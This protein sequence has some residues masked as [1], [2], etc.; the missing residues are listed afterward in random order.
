MRSIHRAAF[1]AVAWLS[2][3]A[4]YA[5]SGISLSLT[6]DG[7][8]PSVPNTVALTLSNGTG[9]DIFIYSYNSAFAQPEG[10]TT[11]NCFNITDAFGHEVDYKGRYVVMGAPPPSLF[12]RIRPGEHLD[13]RV[14][15]SL[16]YEL[17]PA[18]SITVKTRV[19]IYDRV[20]TILPSGESESIPHESIESNAASFVAVRNA[21]H[22]SAAS[23]TIQCTPDQKDTT[24]RAIVGAK[25]IS[26]EAANFLGTLYYID[27]ID[28]EN[29]LPPRATVT[30]QC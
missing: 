5:S 26:E 27:S 28:P 25:S 16:E 6:Y 22:A 20:P 2:A 1:A 7:R 10:R 8:D 3:A 13:A 4:A 19:A 21:A 23:S 17:P 9:H 18:G 30:K 29:P 15:L 12:T 24:R 14:D 11:S